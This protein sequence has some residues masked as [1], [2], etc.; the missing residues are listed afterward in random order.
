MCNL[1]GNHQHIMWRLCGRWHTAVA[2]HSQ[3]KQRIRATNKGNRLSC[4]ASVTSNYFI[5]FF[6]NKSHGCVQ[7]FLPL[8]L[9]SSALTERNQCTFPHIEEVYKWC[10]QCEALCLGWIFAHCSSGH[11]SVFLASR[12]AAAAV[13]DLASLARAF[14]PPPH[15]FSSL[16]PKPSNNVFASQLIPQM[17]LPASLPHP[18][19]RRTP[20]SQG[21][22]SWWNHSRFQQLLF[23]RLLQS[24]FLPPPPPLYPPVQN[25]KN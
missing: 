19:S 24:H 7:L 10:L 8:C 6:L 14:F 5:S 2:H 12:P 25:L 11:T 1:V 22:G 17:C 13:S 20:V 3:W 15:I 18:S 23:F 4:L 9:V 21:S 16:L